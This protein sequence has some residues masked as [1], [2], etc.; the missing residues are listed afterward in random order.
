MLEGNILLFISAVFRELSIKQLLL[1][2]IFAGL[3]LFGKW[4]S[5]RFLDRLARS[6]PRFNH[7]FIPA[8]KVMVK[9]MTIYGSILLFLYFFSNRSWLFYPLFSTDEV[10]VTLYLIIVAIMIVS[11]AHQLVKIFNRYVMTNVYDYYGIDKGMGYTINQIIYY[12]I[13][14]IA[15]II[16]FTTV[17]LDLT[18]VGAVFGVLGIGIGFG[19]RNVAGN[20]VSGIIILFERPIE[21]GEV[22]DINGKIG[23]VEKIRLRSTLVRTA[24]E[25]SL[26]VP[27]QYF[28]EQIIRNRSG[29]EM[30]ATVQI[31]VAYGMDTE[32]V[33]KLLNEVVNHLIEKEKVILM[34]KK[35]VRFIEFRNQ[36]MDFLVEMPVSDFETKLK[37]ESK[38]RHLIAKSFYQNGIELAAQLT[39]S[40]AIQG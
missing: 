28:I 3:L 39:D 25:G 11:L 18:A 37:I 12:T 32:K 7:H 1:F 13:M 36:A 6:K 5:D 16:S 4:L 23:T 26:I 9:W 30:L 17:G 35:E 40:R 21:V 10:K 38:M 20:F 8:I 31:S 2:F 15:L 14:I 29:A 27:N 34:G 22:I 24:K 19:M 33:E